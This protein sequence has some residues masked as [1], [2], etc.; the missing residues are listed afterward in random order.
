[1]VIAGVVRQIRAVVLLGLVSHSRVVVSALPV[2]KVCPSG[3]KAI[4]STPSAWPVRLA[5]G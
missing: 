2:A 4:D 3:L 5:Q 1:M